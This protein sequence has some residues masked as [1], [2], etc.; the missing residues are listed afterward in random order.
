MDWLPEGHLAYFVLEVVR[1]LD[2]GAIESA[3]QAK[4]PRGERPYVPRMMTGLILY[5]YCT[6]LFSSRKIERATHENVPF[7]VT[8]SP[9][10]FGIVRGDS[11]A[12]AS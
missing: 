12:F 10:S 2:L 5:G 8:R 4:A 7:R 1:E 11:S 9:W 3:L 6:G